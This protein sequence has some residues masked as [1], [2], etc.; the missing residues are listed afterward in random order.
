MD[1]DTDTGRTEAGGKSAEH[2]AP[3]AAEV[4]DR[5]AGCRGTDVLDERD[6]LEGERVE[7]RVGGLRNL[8]IAVDGEQGE[9]F[10]GARIGRRA[11]ASSA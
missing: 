2:L 11:A 8:V 4:Q 10:D 3:A 1:V 7:D 5:L 6:L 9:P